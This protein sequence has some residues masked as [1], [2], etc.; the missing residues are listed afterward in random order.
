MGANIGVSLKEKVFGSES[1]LWGLTFAVSNWRLPCFAVIERRM[2]TD[3]MPT[4]IHHFRTWPGS[5]RVSE[6][7]AI[8][9]LLC[10]AGVVEGLR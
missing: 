2:L 6:Y 10:E 8:S 5:V 7:R 3:V 4:R 9:V 1:T